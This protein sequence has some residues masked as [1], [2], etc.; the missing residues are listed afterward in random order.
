MTEIKRP[1]NP[2]RPRMAAGTSTT[3]RTTPGLTGSSAAAD[4]LEGPDE[5]WEPAPRRRLRLTT[6][7]L[8]R[9]TVPAIMIVI[10]GA[11]AGWGASR[12]IPPTYAAHADV[13]YSIT[14][15]QP[16]GFLREDRN[17]TTQL[18]LLDSRT[19]LD[20]VAEQWDIPVTTLAK[21]LDAS[22]V[23]S[24]EIIRITLTHPD[25]NDAQR[26][27]DSIVDRY[28]DV[29]SDDARAEL[30]DYINA[31][32]TDI[33]ARI[34]E[35]RPDAA[36][37]EAELGA[38]VEREQFLRTQLD[39]LQF[40]TIA[41]PAVSV[42]VQPYV[43]PA[44]ASPKPLIMIAAGAFAGLLVALLMVAVALHRMRRS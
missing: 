4:D 8:I 11:G 13:L 20:P 9:L 19:V 3:R 21:E 23:E 22:V 17:I 1:R 14:E 26:I 16:T 38:L 44:P 40:S 12:L 35:L 28:L 2:R 15:E 30:R 41:G 10:L 5:E 34:S 42:L 18:V 39:E 36:N 25:A 43:D 29:S 6:G 33:L 24:S 27:L 37:R 31:Q 7:Q 32:L